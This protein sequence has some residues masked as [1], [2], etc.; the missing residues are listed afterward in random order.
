[1]QN[2]ARRHTQTIYRHLFI[3]IRKYFYALSNHPWFLLSAFREGLRICRGEVDMRELTEEEIAAAHRF[4]LDV[5]ANAD[6]ARLIEQKT[7]V[8]VRSQVTVEELEAVQK[9]LALLNMG[10]LRN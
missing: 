9:E 10:V 6:V 4:I 2:H 5:A 3:M 7:G 1:M 8:D